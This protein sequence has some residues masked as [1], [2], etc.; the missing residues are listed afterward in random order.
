MVKKTSKKKIEDKAA[1]VSKTPA[2]KS[3]ITRRSNAKI[4]T[5]P[6]ESEDSIGSDSS[7]AHSQ[8]T[9]NKDNHSPFSRKYKKNQDTHVPRAD[10]NNICMFEKVTFLNVSIKVKPSNRAVEEVAARLATLLRIL[11][12][13]DSS[14]GILPYKP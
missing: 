6:Q 3:R 5:P 7:S 2:T 4:I 9:C 10:N 14:V 8:N 12:D 13:A 11:K 1:R